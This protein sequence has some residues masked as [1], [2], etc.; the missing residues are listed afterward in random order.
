[1]AKTPAIATRFS[2][3]RLKMNG[4]IEQIFYFGLRNGPCY[5]SSVFQETSR[6]SMGQMLYLA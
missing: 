5:F 2:D 1:M 3:L 6:D 4:L